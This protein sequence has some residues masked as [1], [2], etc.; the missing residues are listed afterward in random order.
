MSVTS[1]ADHRF[2]PGLR[3]L[4]LTKLFPNSVNK[5]GAAFNRQQ[6]LALSQLC[7]VQI[8]ALIPW[9]PGARLF[10]RESEAGRLYSI[11][12]YEHIDGML[13]RH[14]RVFYFPRFAH[15]ANPMT[16]AISLLPVVLPLRRKVDVILGS[17]AYPDGLAAIQLGQWLKL[18]VV[19]KVHGS[20]LNS[21]PGRSG[22]RHVLSLK[23]PCADR[24][25]AVSRPLAAK[26]RE[27][28][29]P[30]DRIAVVPNGVDRA[31]FSPRDRAE[32]R[33]E[34]GL[35]DGRLVLFVGRLE[36]AKG[37]LDLL[38]AFERIASS[39]SQVCLAVV[40]DGTE[41]PRCHQAQASWPGRVFLPGAQP[42]AQVARWVA[43]CDVLTLPSW[44][45][46]SP[47]VVLEAL[48]SGRRVV[49]T[50]VGGIPDLI[51]SSIV[52]EMVSAHR[53]DELVEALLRAVHS[54]YEPM[55]VA[56]AGPPDWQRSASLLQQ[57][58][59]STRD[60]SPL[61]EEVR[62]TALG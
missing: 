44:N 26:A 15:V 41:M 28:G 58:L 52:G 50:R 59:L 43:A 53:P 56:A 47:N 19:V 42:L 25:V 37:V 49:A 35:P 9:F 16:F 23:L 18:P 12:A 17:W 11:P 54:S 61:P 21:L 46:G 48:A 32:A 34:L 10:A 27:F 57:V 13:V 2:K 4:V 14:P 51:T 8:L 5:H 33:R 62:A 29:V 3:V 39:S 36:A 7:D 40:G 45:E 60:G 31:L 22:I 55:V 20:D 38:Q 1:P 30:E 6:F 24:L